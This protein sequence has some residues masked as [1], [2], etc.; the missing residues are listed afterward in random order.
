M[1][2]TIPRLRQTGV[3]GVEEECPQPASALGREHCE[4]LE[5]GDP[6]ACLPRVVRALVHV[7][8]RVCDHRA[9]PARDDDERVRRLQKRRIERPAAR[10][11][12]GAVD[13]AQAGRA[14][15][16]MVVEQRKP[17]RLELGDQLGA[18]ALERDSER[19][20]TSLEGGQPSP[21]RVGSI[22]P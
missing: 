13:R 21:S 22:S 8:E 12:P 14:D 16:E 3:D 2:S 7:D 17:E 4:R 6:L 20:G 18:A 9:V 1:T 5:L 15:G 11:R 10:P 19:L